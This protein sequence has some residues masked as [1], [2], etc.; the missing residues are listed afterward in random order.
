MYSQS[1]LAEGNLYLGRRTR[2]KINWKMC[3]GS[4]S[5]IVAIRRHLSMSGDIWIV[6]PGERMLLA[7]S[8]QTPV[9]MLSISQCTHDNKESL[10]LET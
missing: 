9:M 3:G 6:T 8:G 2:R 7:T 5:E 1:Y 4:A 10:N